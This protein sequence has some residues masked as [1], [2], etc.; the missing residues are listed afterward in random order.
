MEIEE[1]SILIRELVEGYVNDP[2]KGVRAY[3]N[4]LDVRPP[5]QREFRYDEKQKR[6]VIKTI[7]KNYP[8]N[9]MYW[10]VV[11]NDEYEMIDETNDLRRVLYKEIGFKDWLKSFKNAGSYRN[12]IRGDYGLIPPLFITFISRLFNKII[13]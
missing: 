3:G 9:I 10:S 4:R 6:A 13:H 5:Y 11:G 12:Y 1:K 2:D 8:L 7:L